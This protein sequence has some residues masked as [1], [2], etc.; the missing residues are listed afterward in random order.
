MSDEPLINNDEEPYK[1][2]ECRGKTLLSKHLLQ[3]LK[4]VQFMVNSIISQRACYECT[5][6]EQLFQFAVE[7]D[8]LKD[9]V[10]REIAETELEFDDEL[11]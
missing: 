6:C 3:K 11:D 10:L 1:R 5:T 2:R 9:L 4:I 7:I 8:E